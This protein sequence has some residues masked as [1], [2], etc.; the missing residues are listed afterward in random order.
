MSPK[1]EDQIQAR[2]ATQVEAGA[3]PRYVAPTVQE[4]APL[5]SVTGSSK[6]TD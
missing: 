6:T 3:A 5:T 2:P 1:S 4:E